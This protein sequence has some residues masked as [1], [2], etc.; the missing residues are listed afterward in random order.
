M[1]KTLCISNRSLYHTNKV[2]ERNFNPYLCSSV[3][4]SLLKL[5]CNLARLCEG[6]P[7]QPLWLEF[8]GIDFPSH[9]RSKLPFIT[10]SGKDNRTRGG[11]CADTMSALRSP[12]CPPPQY[13]SHPTY[14]LSPIKVRTTRVSRHF[15]LPLCW[16][17]ASLVLHIIFSP[18]THLVI[19]LLFSW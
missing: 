4:C 13:R 15:A 16:S 9:P 8:L 12:I 3:K 18:Y 10:F 19:T 2:K 1:K 6:T 11:V 17:N 14:H 5:L 7:P